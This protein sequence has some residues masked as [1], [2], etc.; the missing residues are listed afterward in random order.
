MLSRVKLVVTSL[1]K[2]DNQTSTE[3]AARKDRHDAEIEQKSAAGIHLFGAENSGVTKS[4]FSAVHR[5]HLRLG[6]LLIILRRFAGR[7]LAEHQRL[8]SLDRMRNHL[9]IILSELKFD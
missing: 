7:N 2:R 6:W 8:L 4:L 5:P 3:T 1:R 9:L